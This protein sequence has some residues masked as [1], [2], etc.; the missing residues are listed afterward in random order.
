MAETRESIIAEIKEIKSRMDYYNS[1]S[2]LEH[3]A[4]RILR[5]LQDLNKIEVGKHSNTIDGLFHT[6]N[7][8]VKFTHH[9]EKEM[10]KKNAA[11]VRKTEFR[12]SINEAISQINIDL[13]GFDLE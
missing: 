5:L 11:K 10:N 3:K 2:E 6:I 7:K 4:E 12:E 1:A 8:E 9:H 13:L